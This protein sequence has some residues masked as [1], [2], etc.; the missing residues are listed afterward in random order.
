M[1]SPIGQEGQVKTEISMLV[2]DVHGRQWQTPSNRS[3][4]VE[5]T[6]LELR[7]VLLKMDLT[8]GGSV[9]NVR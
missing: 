2:S 4:G 7:V 1:G 8:A 5:G 6:G 3:W 9:G